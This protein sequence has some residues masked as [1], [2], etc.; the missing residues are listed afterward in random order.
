MK[1]TFLLILT[2]ELNVTTVSDTSQHGESMMGKFTFSCVAASVLSFAALALVV[3]TASQAQTPPTAKC[4]PEAYSAADQKYVGVPC[5]AASAGTSSP[6]GPEAYSAAE[7]KYVGVPCSAPAQKTADG[8][9]AC[10]AEVYS[11]AEQ[12]YVGVPCPH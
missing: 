3:P 6:C 9:A 1:K 7:Q 8:K 11:V 12:R 2:A 10:G 5:T 4:G